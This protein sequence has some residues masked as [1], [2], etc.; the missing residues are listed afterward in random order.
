[1][2]VRLATVSSAPTGFGKAKD[3]ASKMTAIAKDKYFFI[4]IFIPS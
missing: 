2:M 1:M 4:F 3:P